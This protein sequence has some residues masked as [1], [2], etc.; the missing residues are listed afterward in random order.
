ML[1][2]CKSTSLQNI[3]HLHLIGL[4]IIRQLRQCFL[5]TS[6]SGPSNLSSSAT[7]LYT[8]ISFIWCEDKVVMWSSEGLAI[9]L[10][11]GLW[12][13]THYTPTFILYEALGNENHY[14]MYIMIISYSWGYFAWKEKRNLGHLVNS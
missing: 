13:F 14:K 1:S 3:L 8:C 4:L 2:L 6:L 11:I 10:N 7:T 9:R 5:S 12:E